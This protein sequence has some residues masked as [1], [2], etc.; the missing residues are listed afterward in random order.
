MPQGLEHFGSTSGKGV[1]AL[2][3]GLPGDSNGSHDCAVMQM[4]IRLKFGLHQKLADEGATEQKTPTADDTRG[5]Q[6]LRQK[7][8][9]SRL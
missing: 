8:K 5:S 7:P 1:P 4:T 3:E 6:G 9:G 2:Y